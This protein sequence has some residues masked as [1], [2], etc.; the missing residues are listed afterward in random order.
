[1]KPRDY[2][3]KG[4]EILKTYLKYPH[5]HPLFA[6]PTGGGKTAIEAYSLLLK[7]LS[8][9]FKIHLVMAPRIVLL[10][11]LIKEY[12][13]YIG[14]GYLAMCF[15]SGKLEQDYQEVKWEK[16]LLQVWKLS[17]AKPFVLNP[18]DVIW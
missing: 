4:S 3:A 6:V 18:W 17:Q 16:L 7:G 1:M 2:Q 9:D 5:R 15:H 8:P 13:K 12:R 11:Q 10:N 14:S